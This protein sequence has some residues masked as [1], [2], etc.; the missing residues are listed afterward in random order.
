MGTQC[1]S[2]IWNWFGGR[3]KEWNVSP[4]WAGLVSPPRD[5][6]LLIPCPWGLDFSIWFW[7]GWHIQSIAL[8]LWGRGSCGPRAAPCSGGLLPLLSPATPSGS[9]IPY[10]QTC[11]LLRAVSNLPNL[12]A[13]A[14]VPEPSNH[15]PLRLNHHVTSPEAETLQ[16]HS[17]G[18]GASWASPHNLRAKS[19][20]ASIQFLH[21]VLFSSFLKI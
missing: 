4:R 20:G 16:G 13:G 14:C 11:P 2:Q 7:G 1:M 19:R 5:P 8:S 15:C 10:K 9:S 3:Y 21:A 18:R 6:H 17:W 12:W